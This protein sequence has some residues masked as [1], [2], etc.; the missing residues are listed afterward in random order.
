MPAQGTY[1]HTSIDSK[2]SHMSLKLELTANS[3]YNHVTVKLKIKGNLTLK[4]LVAT[5]DAQWE[6]RGDVGSARYESAL[7]P[8][9]PIIRVLKLQ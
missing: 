2:T 4:V 3:L 6:G 7:L 5:T 9:C 1:W 8:P